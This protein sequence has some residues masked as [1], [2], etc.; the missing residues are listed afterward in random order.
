[1]YKTAPK[2]VLEARPPAIRFAKEIGEFANKKWKNGAQ[3]AGVIASITLQNIMVSM[4]ITKHEPGSPEGEKMLSDFYDA[5]KRDATERW[6]EEDLKN[7]RK[8]NKI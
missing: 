2:E 7:W 8:L 6:H 1:M 4:V 5:V 3:M